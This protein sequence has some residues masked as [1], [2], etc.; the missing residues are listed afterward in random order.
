MAIGILR[1]LIGAVVAIKV[2]DILGRT[3]RDT[4]P[5]KRKKKR[6]SRKR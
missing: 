1:P 6:R 3:I 2:I 5:R 4:S